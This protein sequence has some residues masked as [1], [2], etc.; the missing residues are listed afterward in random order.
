MYIYYLLTIIDYSSLSHIILINFISS[1]YCLSHHFI[2]YLIIILSIQSIFSTP[3]QL[4]CLSSL[5]PNILTNSTVYLLYSPIS[6]LILLPI[7]SIFSISYTNSTAYYSLIPMT[8]TGFLSVYPLF[9][10]LSYY[11]IN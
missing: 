1:S 11:F 9:N 5:F 7:L 8:I 6:S 2:V 10:L 3:H 4:Y